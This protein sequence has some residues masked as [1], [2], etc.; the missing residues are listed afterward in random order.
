MLE[1]EEARKNGSHDCRKI[2]MGVFASPPRK[3]IYLDALRVNLE[4]SGA[5]LHSV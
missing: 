5:I 3:Y 1:A 2:S 4:A